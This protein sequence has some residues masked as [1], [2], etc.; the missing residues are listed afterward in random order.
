MNWKRLIS[1]VAAILLCASIASAETYTTLLSEVKATG[2]SGEVSVAPRTL[3]AYWIYITG[4]ATVDIE[5]AA[6][7]GDPLVK[8]ITG[9]SANTMIDTDAPGTR[10]LVRVMTCTGCTVSAILEVR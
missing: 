7:P 1:A 5:V 8:L 4:T 10:T 6:R 2:P 9:I 3:R